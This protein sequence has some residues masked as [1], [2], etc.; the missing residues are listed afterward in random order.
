LFEGNSDENTEVT[1]EVLFQS[2]PPLN[3]F[4]FKEGRTLGYKKLNRFSFFEN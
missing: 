2:K 4:L 1:Q 3:P